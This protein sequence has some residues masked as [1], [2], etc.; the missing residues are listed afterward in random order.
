MIVSICLP[1]KGRPRMLRQALLSILLQ[2][3]DDVEVV[4]Q[5]AGINEAAVEQPSLRPLFSLLGGRVNY[6]CGRDRGIFDAVNIGLKRSSGDILYFM[7]SDDLLCPGAL[8]AVNENFCKER[9]G[10]PFWLYGQ[11]IS[12][13]S[14]G[15]TLGIDGSLVTYQKLLER[16][17][18]GQ[19]AVFWNRQIM[20]LA[21]MFDSRYKHA[22]DYDLWLRFWKRCAPLYLDQTLGIFRHH[23]SQNTNVYSQAVEDEASRISARH[24]A[25]GDLILRARN[26]KSARE[27]YGGEEIPESVN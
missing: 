7:C 26:I 22:A 18:L 17:R 21:G 15:K 14:R 16:N 6:S 8:F 11:T 23:S 4:I 24:Q 1:V 19:P 5:D 25:F 12:A 2:D 9:F 10:G 20:K 3:Y 13:D 27:C